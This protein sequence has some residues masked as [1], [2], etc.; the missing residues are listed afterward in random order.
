MDNL[1]MLRWQAAE[2]SLEC[3]G[4]VMAELSKSQID[5]LGDRL[6]MDPHTEEDLRLLDEFRN[7]YSQSFEPVRLI[8][9]RRTLEPVARNIKST[10]SIVAKL[11]RQ[12]IRLSRI[13]DIAGC[14]LVVPNV[15]QQNQVVEILKIDFPS[16]AITDRRAKPSHGYRAVHVIVKVHEKPFE[17]QVRSFLQHQWAE[18]SEKASDIVDREIKYGGCGKGF[19]IPIMAI[20]TQIAD[21]ETE[22]MALVDPGPIPTSANITHALIRERMEKLM[23]LR[24]MIAFQVK[25][26]TSILEGIRSAGL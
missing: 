15:V 23:R 21:Y 12:N 11:R 4:G 6:R 22:E 17:I 5:K 8:L 1:Q 24:V 18:L 10:L 25:S 26:L 19:Q 16:A 7:S 9:Q 3:D 14:R 13:Q 2:Y 20:S